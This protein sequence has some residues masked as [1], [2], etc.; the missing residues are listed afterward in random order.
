MD[1]EPEWGLEVDFRAKN[2]PCVHG[3]SID[4]VTEIF[5]K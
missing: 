4:R 2:S 3:N 5:I 1:T